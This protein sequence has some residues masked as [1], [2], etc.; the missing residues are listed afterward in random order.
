MHRA[1]SI[2]QREMNAESGS[3][4]VEGLNNPVRHKFDL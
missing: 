3:V 4:N 1:K 2:A